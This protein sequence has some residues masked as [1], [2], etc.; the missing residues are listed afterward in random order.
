MLDSWVPWFATAFFA[1]T[2]LAIYLL[3][4]SRTRKAAEALVRAEEAGEQRLDETTAEHHRVLEATQTAHAT[5]LADEQ[6]RTHE[7]AERGE[8]FRREAATRIGWDLVSRD[9]IVGACEEVGLTGVLATNIVFVPYDARALTPFAAQIDHVLLTDHAALV[10]ENK[11]WRGIVFDGVRPSAVDASYAAV[12]DDTDLEPPFS[13][14]LA[15]EE[16]SALAVRTRRGGQSPQSQVRLQAKRLS[17]LVR[18]DAGEPPWFHT[19]VL[20]SNS[21]VLLHTR[22]SSPSATETDVV[23]PRTLPEVLARIHGVQ[24][25]RAATSP[26]QLVAPLLAARGADMYGLGELSTER[27]RSRSGHTWPLPA[28]RSAS[29]QLLS[30]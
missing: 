4:R 10:I 15:P 25:R 13:I 9:V 5:A 3:L 22:P 14:Q 27:I 26:L 17:D 28:D 30:R 12:L 1:A 29:A 6:A 11:G 2:A 18:A 16:D 20:Y 21:R 24:R 23:T 7:A 8:E 19:C